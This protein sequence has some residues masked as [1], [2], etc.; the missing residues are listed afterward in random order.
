LSRK[1]KLY[2]KFMVKPPR[3]DL[4]FA[5]LETLLSGLGYRKLEC[6]GSRVKFF[7]RETEDLIALH[8]PHPGN[9]LKEYQVK[10]IQDH[11]KKL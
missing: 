4:T 6:S 2:D 10:N 1:D 9:E 8:K 11:L 3:K 7:N 5:E